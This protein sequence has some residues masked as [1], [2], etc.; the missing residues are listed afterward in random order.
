MTRFPRLCIIIYLVLRDR[1]RTGAFQAEQIIPGEQELTKRFGVSRIT[2][3]RALNE[4]AA[5][6]LVSRQ[7]GRGT[8]VT[9]NA[10]IPVVRGGFDGLLGAL[11]QM[12]LTTEVEVLEVVTVVAGREIA[13]A[14]EMDRGLPVQRAIRLRRLERDTF[15]YLV[16]Y[17][18]GD[19]ADRYDAEELEQTPQ[20]ALLERLGVSVVE[21]EQSIT[22][23]AAE[24]H[25]AGALRIAPGSPLLKITRLM[26]DADGRPV[27]RIIAYYR[28]DRFHYHLHL[29][30][31]GD[32]A[33]ATEM[34][35]S[36]AGDA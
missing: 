8:V 7:R 6:G 13:E 10:S 24:P 12:G 18:P 30:R 28:P 14:M 31:R 33:S 16:S 17:V 27:Q 25:V 21:A 36:K 32:S 3:K 1:I 11:K 23:V 22:A 2:V 4:L 19:I 34:W 5:H 35:S 20:L 29:S 15:S 9:Y 26:R